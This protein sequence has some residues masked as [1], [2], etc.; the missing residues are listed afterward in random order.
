MGLDQMLIMAGVLG[1]RLVYKGF[2]HFTTDARE[3]QLALLRDLMEKNANTEYGKKYGFADIKT[4]E[5]YRERVPFASYDDYEPYIKRMIA[6]EQNLLTADKINRYVTTSGSSSAPKLIP[7]SGK[8]MW[9]MHCMGFIAPEACIDRYYKSKGKKANHHKGLLTWTIRDERLPNGERLS[10]G[11][12]VPITNM[13]AV[14]NLYSVVP[15]DLVFTDEADKLDVNYIVLRCGL[16]YRPLS[17]IGCAIITSMYTMFRYLEKNWEVLCDDIERGVISEGVAVTPKARQAMKKQLRPDPKRA[18]ELRAE[19]RKGFDT[20]IATRI[21]PDLSWVYGMS[22]STLSVY[23]QKVRRYI[24]DLPIHTFGYGASEGY[25][26]MP[27]SPD[28]EDAAQQ[29]L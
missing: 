9:N 20:P 14:L 3:T 5:Q 4:P 17:F 1:G 15:K 6:G 22:G 2:E 27:V 13:R 24:G 25:F 21:W 23:V 11:T 19:F 8:T 12:S 28:A 29:F 10:V 16:M 18:A 26:A 7:I